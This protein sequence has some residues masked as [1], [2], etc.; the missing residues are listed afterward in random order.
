M[1]L[2]KSRLM[3][4]RQCSR[5]LWLELYRPEL[6][7]EGETA[8]S[9]SG[10]S[11]GEFARGLYDDGRAELVDMD[12]EGFP[13]V[14]E[15]T[16]RL[17]AE[18]RTIFEA[19]LSDGR[20]LALADVL[21]PLPEGGW[22]LV[23]V[24]SSGSVKAYQQDD[25]AI[26]AHIAWSAGL[27][28]RQAVLACI[29]TSWVYQG[30][31]NYRGLFAEYDQTALCRIRIPETAVLIDAA[32][33][34]AE[35]RNS[36]PQIEPGA[37][38]YSPHECPFTPWCHR[39][40]PREAHPLDWLPNRNGRLNA[41]IEEH[42]IRNLD[43]LPD[44]PLSPLQQRVRHCSVQDTVYFDQTGA[45]AALSAAVFPLYFLD[46]ESI[47]F[48][49]PRWAGTRPYQQLV[50]QYSL[51][52]Q[53]SNGRLQHC[54]FLDLSG[55]N[56][57][58]AFAERLLRDCGECGTIYVYNI[59]FERSRVN[60]LAVQFSDLAAALRALAGRMVDLLPIVK[61]YYYH[62]GQQGSWSLKRVLPALAPDLSY[63]DLEGVRDGTAAMDAYRE[64]IEP[65]TADQ[66]RE[67]LGTQLLE[68]C[69]LDTWSLVRIWQ[70][71][72]N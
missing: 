40:L 61:E 66:R 11:V 8:A 37:Q 63:A 33:A 41:Y 17:M 38:C 4:F 30:D 64:A 22:K 71:L 52:R 28:L 23:E 59:T 10:R 60:E 50:F 18:R 15:H 24:K 13:A 62:P 65:A 27:E 35:D 26:Q 16:K 54:E 3:A 36:E 57:L 58:R 1:L 70:A 68:Y 69:K 12:A 25:L 47:Q 5:R 44:E 42:G 39:S 9:S 6:R 2:S 48:A 32:L 31:G 19:A 45:H 67:V 29:N 49:V 46:F 7:S 53:E 43:E 14:F 55:E 72:D 51:H 21:L 34:L 20:A 56:P